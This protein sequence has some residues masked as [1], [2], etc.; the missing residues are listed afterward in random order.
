MK[1]HDFASRFERTL[2]IL[3]GFLLAVIVVTVAYQVF[4]R[5]VLGR[6]PSWSEGL[7][8]MLFAW[9]TMLGAASSLRAGRHLSITA[10]LTAVSE[11]AQ[12]T[13]LWLRNGAMLAAFV[14]LGV[15]SYR[16]IDCE[17]EVG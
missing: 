13:L 4:G 9:M 6:S 14:V 3:C 5:Y 7:C 17:G 10:L 2:D 15:A 11:R 12:M 1:L 8:G 16:F